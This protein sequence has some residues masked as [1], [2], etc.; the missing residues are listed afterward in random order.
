LVRRLTSFAALLLTVFAVGQP[1]GRFG[2]E[3]GGTLPG[4][5]LEKHGFRVNSPKASFFRYM[6]PTGDWRTTEISDMGKSAIVSTAGR[7]PRKIHMN[8][9][10]PGF[11]L[12]FESGS[13]FVVDS[14][15]CP[16]LTW[17]EGSVGAGV[18][19][20][21]TSWVLVSFQRA[22]PPVLFYFPGERCAMRV[23]GAPGA[24]VLRSVDLTSQWVRVVPPLGSANV[25]TAN[26]RELGALVQKV[27]PNLDLW[28]APEPVLRQTEVQSDD[29]SA[30]V[31]WHFEHALAVIPAAPLLAAFG[32]YPVQI[33]S[34]VRDL[35]LATEDGPLEVCLSEDLVVRFPIRRLNL[36]RAV[37]DG[38]QTV[39]SDV[40]S[41]EDVAGIVDVAL[42]NLES[43]CGPRTRDTGA[44]LG[45]RFIGQVKNYREPITGQQL[46]F[47]QDGT[48]ADVAAAYALLLAS[49]LSTA[50]QDV[51]ANPLALSLLLKRDWQD[52]KIWCT[53]EA[54]ARR[55]SAL[56]AVAC[57]LGGDGRLRSDAGMLEAGLAAERGLQIWRSKADHEAPAPM[58]EPLD[59]LRKWLFLEGAPP[60]TPFIEALESPLWVFADYPVSGRAALAGVAISWLSQEA[61]PKEVVVHWNE[62]FHVDR[63]KNVLT[64]SARQVALG[65]TVRALPADI[66]PTE[67]LLESQ[68]KPAILKFSPPPPYAENAR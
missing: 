15:A 14:E 53:G 39:P 59:D 50:G 11:S 36:G 65:T 52:W 6:E 62:P 9:L 31:S 2:Y 30:T 16:Y 46:P 56:A 51:R 55:S 23:D 47:E 42:S 33:L 4:F 17:S 60:T 54:T 12:Y 3:D 44:R 57:A 18:P 43:A 7:A 40:S 21:P 58:T 61:T 24:W 27:L 25:A 26:A 41:V 49:S 67:I 10:T 32:G 68:A 19:T 45:A 22:Q 66:G 63:G 5:V 35:G 8:L 48:G 20:P 1:F 29:E 13:S 38:A 28:T 34:P 37:V 64:I